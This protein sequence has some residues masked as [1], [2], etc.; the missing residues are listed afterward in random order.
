MGV[1]FADL[2][3]NGSYDI[4]VSN[5]TTSWGIHESNFA[6]INTATEPAQMRQHLLAGE[7]PFEDRSA[8]LGMA[9]SGWGWDVKMADLNNN[10]RVEV[11]QTTGFVKGKFNRWAQLQEMATTNDDLV[12]NPA[13]WPHVR[14]GD[15][16]AGSQ[17]P[18]FFARSDSGRFVNLSRALGLAVPIPT[19][20]VALGDATG[21]GRL[22]LAIARQWE[23]PIFYRNDSPGTG[24][25]LGLRLLHEP[26]PDSTPAAGGLT[27][28]G[29]PVVGAQVRVTT[30]DGNTVI[31]HVDGGSGHAGK[32]S[33]DVHIGLGT[34]TGRLSVSIS[35][36]DRTG[37]VREQVL[38]LEPGWHV[39]YL[40]ERVSEG[41]S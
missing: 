3:G 38:Q 41:A 26:G 31:G 13:L 17:P 25:F 40:G 24:G 16:I 7:A 29:S 27:P 2:S 21:D 4:F 14:E 39:L 9:W 19:R 5:I 35:W 22:D 6:F 15:D 12:S 20:G 34:A 33:Q 28:T 36:R 30:T 8:T 37:Q 11:V 18:A 32:R 1:D 23:E 10:G